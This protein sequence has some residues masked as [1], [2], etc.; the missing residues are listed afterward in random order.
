MIISNKII[1]NQF[2]SFNVLL[3]GFYLGY[4]VWG[5]VDP[6]IFFWACSGKK[7]VFRPSGGSGA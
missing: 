5:G 1:K 4:F 2:R 3:P 7:I 6:K